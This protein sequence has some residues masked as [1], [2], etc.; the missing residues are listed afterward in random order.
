MVDNSSCGIMRQVT[1]FFMKQV[2]FLL[3]WRVNQFLFML[4]S[5]VLLSVLDK[6]L[7]NVWSV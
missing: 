5:L 7:F 6:T 2:V 4:H 3:P 1:L